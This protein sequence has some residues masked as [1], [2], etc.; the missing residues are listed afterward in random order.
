MAKQNHLLQVCV[1]VATLQY[2]NTALQVKVSTE[3]YV[4]VYDM[5]YMI[6][7]TDA[8]MHK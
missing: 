1:Q 3:V 8:L 5:M 6:T 4:Y 7:M 2:K